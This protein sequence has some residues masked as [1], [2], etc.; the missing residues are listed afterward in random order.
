MRVE[1][2]GSVPRAAGAIQAGAAA[3]PLRVVATTTGA[4]TRGLAP[5][6][7]SLAVTSRTYWP[8][9]TSDP[10]SA[11]PSQ[12][13]APGPAAAAKAMVRTVVP[14]ASRIVA[15]T[16]ACSESVNATPALSLMPSPFGVTRIGAPGMPLA[17]STGGVASSVS[18]ARAV[19][20]GLPQESPAVTTTVYEPSGAGCPVASRPPQALL[21]VGPEAANVA[22]LVPAGPSTETDQSTALLAVAEI[23]SLIHI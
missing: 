18:A 12:V 3:T 23:L 6:A 22:T 16:A 4:V 9:G 5:P 14:A 2:R 17:V 19:A 15:A 1:T 20:G 13:I 21:S 8:S 11:R 10:A 7:A